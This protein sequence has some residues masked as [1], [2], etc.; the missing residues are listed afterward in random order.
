[1]AETRDRRPRPRT[2]TVRRL[3]KPEQTAR[4]IVAAIAERGAEP[5][6]MLASEAAMLKEYG[7]GRATLREALRLLE[8]QG[9]VRLRPGPGGGPIV[10]QSD[11]VNLS[12]TASLHFGFN[13]STYGEL[14]EATL[15]IDPWLAVLAA[16]RPDRTSVRRL[17]APYLDERF[18]D[19]AGF[20]RSRQFRD[21]HHAVRHLSGNS[22]LALWADVIGVLFG[23]HIVDAIDFTNMHEHVADVHIEIA[24]AIVDG[25]AAKTRHL[26]I[27]HTQEILAFCEQA[28]PGFSHRTIQWR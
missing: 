3:K 26:M 2:T 4:A 15:S 16:S 22:V 17:L 14:G 7:V 10:G 18:D 6:D 12:R 23:D 25:K 21:F 20:E 13:G 1:M 24:H 5:G 19:V 11:A 27:E 28:D 8:N 9:L